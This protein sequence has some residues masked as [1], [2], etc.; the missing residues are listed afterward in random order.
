MHPILL[1]ALV[2]VAQ[3]SPTITVS[4]DKGWYSPGEQVMVRVS[5]TGFAPSERL[6]L[7]VDKPDGH[8]LYFTEL[9]ASGDNIIVTLPQ[10]VPDGIYT[11]TVAWDH[12]YVE[13][14]FV[15]QSQPVPEFPLAFLVLILALT[16]ASTSIS[17]R[18][19]SPSAK[20]PATDSRAHRVCGGVWRCGR[21]SPQ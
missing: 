19:A 21:A 13:T 14:G 7:Y 15:V 17:R 18:K 12:R 1:V 11:I 20:T 8:N 10:D 3:V 6:W 2:M 9:P 5:T 16:V 4:T